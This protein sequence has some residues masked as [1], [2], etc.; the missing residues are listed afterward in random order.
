VA[1]SN[2]TFGPGQN[3]RV[4]GLEEEIRVFPVQEAR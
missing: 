1:G 3:Q 2:I 4:K